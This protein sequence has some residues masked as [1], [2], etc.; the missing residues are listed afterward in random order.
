MPQSNPRTL[1][2]G[3]DDELPRT[4]VE[5][6]KLTTFRWKKATSISVTLFN[7]VKKHIL[8]EC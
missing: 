3:L 4:A 7:S 1:F 5:C 6:L 8:L 2:S